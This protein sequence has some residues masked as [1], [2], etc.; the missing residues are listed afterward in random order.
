M[1]SFST[2]FLEMVKNFIPISE[3]G[4]IIFFDP[5]NANMEILQCNNLTR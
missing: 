4:K 3:K 5:K 1:D 2:I